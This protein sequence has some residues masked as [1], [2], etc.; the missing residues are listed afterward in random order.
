MPVLLTVEVRCNLI[1]DRLFYLTKMINENFEYVG[2]EIVTY[3][4]TDS[5]GYYKI[6]KTT[7]LKKRI[8]SFCGTNPTFKIVATVNMDIESVLHNKFINQRVK[9]EWFKLLMEDV[10]CLISEYGFVLSDETKSDSQK[11]SLKQQYERVIDEYVRVFENKHDVKLDFW[12]GDDKT[13]PA[14]F[15]YSYFFEPSDIMFDVNNNLPK[16]MPFDWVDHYL[17][18]GKFEKR[19]ISLKEYSEGMRYCKPKQIQS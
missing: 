2:K 14:C 5:S 8:L 3:I 13:I 10:L 7:D 6:G 1:N 19:S 17:E 15:G 11:E 4:A 12:V 16:G 18:F 9:G